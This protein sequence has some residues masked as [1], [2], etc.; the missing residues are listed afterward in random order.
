MTG[1]N[2]GTDLAE[3]ITIVRGEAATSEAEAT[4][5]TEGTSSSLTCAEMK[6]EQVVHRLSSSSS[7]SSSSNSSKA[8]TTS[9]ITAEKTGKQNRS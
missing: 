8:E 3:A 2:L 5:G 1:S 6:G 7:S 4:E 9:S